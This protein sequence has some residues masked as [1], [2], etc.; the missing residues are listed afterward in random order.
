MTRRAPRAPAC[1]PAFRLGDWVN[2]RIWP[3]RCYSS[4]RAPR[5]FTP[6]I[7]ST[8]TAVTLRVDAMTTRTPVAVIGA[9]LMGHGI[10]QVFALA[11][12]SVRVH[13]PSV[14]VLSTL[15]ERIDRNL[16]DLN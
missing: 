1:W 9:G 3:V 12:H 2:P 14:A 10:A 7:F 8:R 11:G 13:D 5:T 16:R 6:D 4:R 15:R